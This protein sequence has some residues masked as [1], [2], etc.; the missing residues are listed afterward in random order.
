ML[1]ERGAALS[2]SV[3]NQATVALFSSEAENQ[4]M[5]AAVQEALYLKEPLEDFSIQQKH[6][7]AIE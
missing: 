4:G 7:I 2:W 1:N 3:K 6:P 5:A